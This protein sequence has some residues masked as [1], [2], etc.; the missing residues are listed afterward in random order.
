MAMILVLLVVLP[1]L[2]GARELRKELQRS[3]DIYKKSELHY[4]VFTLKHKDD[5]WDGWYTWGYNELD[6]AILDAIHECNKGTNVAGKCQVYALGNEIVVGLEPLQLQAK[7]EEYRVSGMANRSY[8]KPADGKFVS[9][10]FSGNGHFFAGFLSSKIKS[11]LF[12]YDM[13]DELWKHTSL[14]KTD[15]L[16]RDGRSFSLGKDGLIYAYGR[17]DQ[18]STGRK[19]ASS[20]II[21]GWDDK[22]ITE[23]PL[24]NGA[25]WNGGC[26]LS[27]SPDGHDVAVCIDE[28]P[29]TRVIRYEIKTGKR[30]GDFTSERLKGKFNQTLKYSPDGKFLLV[31]GGRYQFDWVLKKNG[32]EAELAWLFAVDSDLLEKKLEFLLG[33]GQKG[34]ED[35]RFSTVG[36]DVLVTTTRSITIHSIDTKKVFSR[37]SDVGVMTLLSPHNVLAVADGS[38]LSMFKIIGD[39]LVLIDSEQIL[40]GRYKLGFDRERDQLVIVGDQG[41]T[42][43]IGFRQIDLQS[44]ALYKN[45]GELFEQGKYKDGMATLATIIQ[46]NPKLPSGFSAYDFYKKYPEI[47][48]AYFGSLFGTHIQRILEISPKVSRLGFGYV[49][50]PKSGLYF[51]TVKRIDAGTSVSRSPVQVGDRITHINGKPVVLATQI[52]DILAPLPP[53][54]R[55]E[56][57]YMRNGRIAKTNVLTEV[58]F[59][60]TGKTAH[61][62]LA[63]F[64]YGQLAA[65][66]GH[67]GLARY[68]AVRL[69]AISGQ[70]PSSFRTDL[71]EKLAV[72]LEALAF[73]VEGNMDAGFELLAKSTPHPFQFRLFNPLVWGAFYQDRQRL[74][75]AIGVPEKKLPQFDGMMGGKNQDFPDLSGQII[76]AILPPQ[77]LR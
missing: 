35:I 58:G 27:L 26:G 54:R 67:P 70:Y 45:A 59:K 5:R 65:Q 9:L 15:L 7:I 10:G 18:S 42:S 44:I 34:P 50:D 39:G 33:P 40:Y 77:L 76:P 23:I 14:L 20:I 43:F 19:G 63:L 28:G 32:K 55:I 22:D 52:N 2:C 11:R 61:V 71:V 21:K 46:N 13:T 47:P 66:A 37:R 36:H 53:G 72:S 57:T 6:A 73:S 4:K 74:A 8:P 17:Y 49:K 48:L 69:R 1:A 68:A 3:Y 31:Q 24:T 75:Q 25:F 56:L 16:L 41:I 29:L 60:D 64:D 30:L 62:L 12:I 38:E 51:T